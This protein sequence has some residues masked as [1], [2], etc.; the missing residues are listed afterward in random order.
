MLSKQQ[1][2]QI[3]TFKLGGLVGIG[4]TI[5]FIGEEVKSNSLSSSSPINNKFCHFIAVP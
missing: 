5:S 4:L 3:N 2:I 1:P